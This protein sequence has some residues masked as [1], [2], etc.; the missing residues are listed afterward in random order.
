MYVLGKNVL[1]PDALSR[2]PIEKAPKEKDTLHE[3]K[4]HI[5][6]VIQTLLCTDTRFNKIEKC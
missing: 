6:N 3:E 1:V 4:L 5:R 2:K